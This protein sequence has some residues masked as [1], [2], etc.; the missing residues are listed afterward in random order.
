METGTRP[1]YPQ[2]NLRAG[3]IRTPARPEATLGMRVSDNLMLMV[4]TPSGTLWIDRE[5]FHRRYLADSWSLFEALYKAQT[6][7]Q[8]QVPVEEKWEATRTSYDSRA[9]PRDDDIRQTPAPGSQHDS[10]TEAHAVP[11]VA[12]RTEPPSAPEP[13]LFRNMGCFEFG[14]WAYHLRWKLETEG[15]RFNTPE[16]RLSYLV[17]HMSGP[18]QALMAARIRSSLQ[19]PIIDVNDALEYLAYFYGPPHIMGHIDFHRSKMDTSDTSQDSHRRSITP[20]ANGGTHKDSFGFGNLI[21]DMRRSEGI[22]QGFLGRE[23]DHSR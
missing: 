14:N 21:C 9:A 3:Q 10:K 12:P 20:A 15:H 11:T 18:P 6:D 19:P 4:K 16:R 23:F 13:P 7:L 1:I 17:E 5:N 2:K 8:F 22:K